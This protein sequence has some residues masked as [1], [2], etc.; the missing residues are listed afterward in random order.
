MKKV[1]TEERLF[2]DCSA[3]QSNSIGGFIFSCSVF[4]QLFCL[5]FKWAFITL[6]CEKNAPQTEKLIILQNDAVD[7]IRVQDS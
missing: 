1:E 4:W 2:C 6:A 7:F 3:A 5:L